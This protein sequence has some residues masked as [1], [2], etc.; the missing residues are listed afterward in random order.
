[1][2]IFGPENNH[3][4]F[5]L[6]TSQIFSSKWRI[7]QLIQEKTEGCKRKKLPQSGHCSHAGFAKKN[8]KKLPHSCLQYIYPISVRKIKFPK[9]FKI[10]ALL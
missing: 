6:N 8:I 1:M 10:S 2:R 4:I 3:Q 9:F 5:T 7:I